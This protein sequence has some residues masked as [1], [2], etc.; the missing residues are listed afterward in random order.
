[1][2]FPKKIL[3]IS[4]IVIIVAVLAYVFFI[5]NKSD[6]SKEESSEET[7]EEARKV[8]EVSIPVKAV[9][10][11][12]EDL[13]IKLK[14]PGEAVT[15]MRIT[16]T[17]E[18]SGIIKRLNVE[19]SKHVKKG[20]LLVGLDDEMYRLNLDRADAERLRV[21]SE[22]LVEKQFDEP[23][24]K[25]IRP[26]NEKLKKAQSDYEKARTLYRR[27][28]TSTGEFER[29]SKEYEMALIESG[30]KKEE[31]LA[32]TKGLTQAEIGVKEAQ[33]NLA[34]TKIRAPFSGI[35]FDINVSPGE[36]VTGS[37]ELFT[38][39]NI[40]RIQVQAK[41]LESE[42]GKIK[43][44]RGADLRF[45]AYPGETFK[46]KI[47]AISPVVDPEDKTCKVII[48]VANPGGE[49]KPGMH[50]EVE[51]V[52]EVYK[53]RLLVPQ[54]AVLVRTGGRKL[55]FV[56][57]SGLAKW[58]YIEIGLENEHYAE[59]LDGVKEGELVLVEGHS[60]LAHDAKIRITK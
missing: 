30:A 51:I 32:A 25:R 52:A 40:N 2:I 59:V 58:R 55:V 5:A 23:E 47:E 54:E 34:K 60:T 13:I 6:S 42:I 31:I 29:A 33:M 17:A 19:E 57:E 1:M 3:V 18:V 39:V 15:N 44:G 53:D 11:K 56:E 24:E 8:E 48:D 4:L 43:V 16:M 35:I 36:H 21:L 22:F 7:T 20:D 37:R 26:D 38:L 9:K 41:V 49:I 14:S 12:R 27:G 50:T 46:G 10:A 45:S 28:R